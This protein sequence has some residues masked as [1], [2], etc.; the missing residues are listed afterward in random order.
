MNIIKYNL[1]KN[2]TIPDYIIDG[3]YFPKQNNNK[4]PQDLDLIGLS[5]NTGL[6][7]YT[8]K[9]DFEDYIKSFCDNSYEINN[10]IRY[11]QDMIDFIWDK[12]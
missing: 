1:N 7:N 2:G 12:K 5:N 4:S 9:T 3:G 6:E 11:I 8:N 10:K